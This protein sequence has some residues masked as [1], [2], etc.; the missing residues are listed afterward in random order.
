MCTCVVNSTISAKHVE[1]RLSSFCYFVKTMN[2][3]LCFQVTNKVTGT[4]MDLPISPIGQ[5][6]HLTDPMVIGKEFVLRF[7]CFLYFFNLYVFS[8]IC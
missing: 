3:I 4:N 8:K 2:I 5:F 7:I 1:E 6:T